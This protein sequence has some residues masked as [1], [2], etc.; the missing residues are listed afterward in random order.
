MANEN[1]SHK[2]IIIVL[3]IIISVLLIVVSFF[4]GAKIFGKQQNVSYRDETVTGLQHK[5]GYKLSQT[6]V[7]S[8]HNIRSPLATEGSPLT[9]LTPHKW[10]NWTSP[11]S[12][13]S[14]K[15]GILETEMGQYFRKYLESEQLIPENYM[16]QGDETLFYTNSLQRTIATGQYFSSGMLPVANSKIV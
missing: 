6:T 10:Y 1:K 16:P 3:L 15:G 13:L 9:K 8:R 4:C 2:S 5:D 12:Q 7:L 14:L 11:G